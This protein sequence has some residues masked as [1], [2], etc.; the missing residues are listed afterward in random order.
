MT[1]YQAGIAKFQEAGAQVFGVST[2]SLP[3]LRHWAEE[4][5]QAT[6]PM[7]SDFSTRDTAKKFGVMLPNGMCAR[8]TFVVDADGKIQH[9]DEGSAAIDPTGA[10]TACSR[11]K[12]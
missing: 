6:F 11:V 12:K 2:D 3:S 1:A 5:I 7:L 9:I 10:V 4:H 8:T